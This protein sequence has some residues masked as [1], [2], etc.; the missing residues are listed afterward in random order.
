METQQQNKSIISIS[1]VMHGHNKK[2]NHYPKRVS[3][4]EEEK[5]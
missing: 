1:T 4:E 3:K 5:N 2:T